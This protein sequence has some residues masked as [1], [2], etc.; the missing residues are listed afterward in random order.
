VS[1]DAQVLISAEP[2][3]L[4]HRSVV[5]LAEL[6]GSL[7]PYALIGGLAVIARLGHAHR[8]TNDIDTVSDD[9]DRVIELLV[10]NGLTRTGESVL[11]A[12]DLKLDVIDV[13]EGD[14]TYFPY[15]SHRFGFD[16]RTEIEILVQPAGGS[17]AARATVPVARAAALVAIKLGIS[18]GIGRQRDTMKAGSD[19]F[20]VARLLQQSGPDAIADELAGLATEHFVEQVIALAAR[21]LVDEADRTA[22]AIVRSNVAG[23]VRIGADQLE[24]LGSAF[25]RRLGGGRKEH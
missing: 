16:T 11:L 13:S 17:P 20:D 4:L 15:L 1:G 23:V 24:L 8:A 21:H 5:R 2:E 9:R 22:S 19:A 12:P 7:Q 18:E 10:A 14:E 6:G 3:S 25:I